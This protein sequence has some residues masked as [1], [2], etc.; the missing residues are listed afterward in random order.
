MKARTDKHKVTI[1]GGG[2]ITHVFFLMIRRPPR[3]T[4]FPYTTLFRSQ[5]PQHYSIHSVFHD[6][7]KQQSLNSLRKIRVSP[8]K[9]VQKGG[10][11]FTLSYLISNLQEQAF[12]IF[13]IFYLQYIQSHLP[14]TFQLFLPHSQLHLWFLFQSLL[15]YA[16]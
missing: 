9:V 16:N 14:L 10:C 8:Q 4:L 1:I 13:Q 6:R 11:I 3:S 12:D 7:I 5:S 15:W 2:M